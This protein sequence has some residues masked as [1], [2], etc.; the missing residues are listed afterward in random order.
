MQLDFV[1]ADISDHASL[2]A[3]VYTVSGLNSNDDPP[4]PF[5]ILQL[6]LESAP[7]ELVQLNIRAIMQIIKEYSQNPA[8][9]ENENLKKLLF[10]C[11]RN[12]SFEKIRRLSEPGS[13]IL[14]IQLIS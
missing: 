3:D 9:D 12:G 14:F 13:T 11:W 4:H 7:K 6:V 8:G 10:W 5:M 2:D 1:G